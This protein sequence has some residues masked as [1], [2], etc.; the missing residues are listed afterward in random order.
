MEYWHC[1]V[2]DKYF[3]DKD[4]VNEIRPEDTVVEK[5]T[6]A[7]TSNDDSAKATE[8]VTFASHTHVKTTDASN[9]SEKTSPKTGHAVPYFR[10]LILFGGCMLAGISFTEKKK[11]KN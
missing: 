3:S 7:T 10:V 5:L 6:A 11:R 1:D 4:G 9:G 2:C 8:K